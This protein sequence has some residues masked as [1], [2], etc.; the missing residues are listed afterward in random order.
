MNAKVTSRTL[1]KKKEQQEPLVMVTAYDYPAAKLAEEAGVD[2]ILV[3]DSVGTTVLGY[4]ST[5]PVT[6]DDML[7]HTK[8]VTRAVERVLVVTDLPFAVAHGTPQEVIKAAARLMQEGGCYGVKI[9]G[10]Q[11]MVPTI[12]ALT[13]AGIPVMGHIGLTPQSVNQLGGYRYQGKE[14]KEAEQML[15]TA[16]ELEKAGIFALVMECVPEELAEL[17]TS[18]LSIPVIG[19][20]SG[21]KCDG[22]VLVYHDMLQLGSAFQPS[23]VKSY[24]S[25]GQATLQALQ[26]FT[27]D[28]RTRRFP[29]EKHVTHLSPQVLASLQSRSGSSI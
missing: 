27:D 29:E 6:L 22:Q 21:R 28:V 26:A 1:R 19:I 5:I 13:R 2:L 9:E 11:T 12:A 14:E 17:I 25:L 3:G 20:G 24:A 15:E 8:A 23:F 10:D 7:H 4:D 18:R 16:R